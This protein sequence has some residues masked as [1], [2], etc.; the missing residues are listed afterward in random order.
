MSIHIFRPPDVEID[1]SYSHPQIP[2][3]IFLSVCE[4][5]STISNF[6]LAESILHEAM[7]LKLTLIENIV[8]L[9]EANTNTLF[10]SPW[11]SE[12]RPIKGV[13]HGLFVFRAI[14]EFYEEL[15]KTIK[16]SEAEEYFST[17]ISQIK[18]EIT[19]LK[20]FAASSEL[21]VEG[22]NLSK[23]LLPLN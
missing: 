18:N 17:R 16:F 3:S 4:D 20:G 23:N 6:R 9:V 2:F 5:D 19:L 10:Y 15:Y 12:E 22:A 1:L 14:K 11:R 7:H 21:T 8:P 13:L